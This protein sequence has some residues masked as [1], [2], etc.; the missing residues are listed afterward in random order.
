MGIGSRIKSI[1][2]HLFDVDSNER[3]KLIYLTLTFFFVI[4]A[5]TLARDLKNSIF[6]SMVGRYYVNWARMISMFFLVPMILFYS[7][8]VDAMRRYQL[9]MFYSILFGCVALVFAYLL[10]HPTIGLP[11]TNQSPDRIFGWL[12]Y[13]FVEAYSPFVVSV[14]WA[15]AN[16]INSPESA[17]K[18]YGLMVS[19]S[20]LGGMVTA[21]F[22]WTL[23]SSIANRPYDLANDVWIHQ[24]VLV[25]SSLVLLCV[26][27]MVAL[28]M[29]RVPGQY[30]HGYEAAYKAEKQKAKTKERAGLFEGLFML[31]K[32]PYVMGIFSLIMFYEIV[33]TVLGYLRLGV[34]E[35]G[36]LSVSAKSAFLFKMVFITH[37]VGFL[38]SLIGT[39]TLLRRLGTR[40]CLLLIPLIS[41]GLLLYFMIVGSAQALVMT[42]ALLKSVNYAFSW[43]VR[44]SLYIPTIKDIKFKSKSWIDAFGAK[45]AKT[46][47]STF[48]M[49]VEGMNPALY[50]PV[51]A[52]FLAVLSFC[53]L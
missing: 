33:G 4:G 36:A 34:A 31:I 22:A 51:H 23:F 46:G 42:F 28:L 7:R 13:F 39:R 35:S 45:F 21:G 9:L 25:V 40:F 43:P 3:S 15:F 20:K 29:K 8:L 2:G 26:P 14:F 16:S 50:M 10:G 5:Y 11:N 27:I 18:N 6:I 17:K 38:I 32:Y 37:T 19:G 52:F 30:L 1:F 41:G 47:G 48:N 49:F 12:F 53:G 44:E 24:V